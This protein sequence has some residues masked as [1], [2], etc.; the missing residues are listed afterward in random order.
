MLQVIQIHLSALNFKMFL[1]FHTISEWEKE[2]IFQNDPIS[3]NMKKIEKET[4]VFI[5]YILNYIETI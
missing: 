1:F 4:L 2:H 5:Q 3:I